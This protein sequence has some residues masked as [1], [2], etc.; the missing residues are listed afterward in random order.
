[1]TAKPENKP[2][3]I[4]EYYS[5]EGPFEDWINQFESIAEINRWGD[6]QKLRWLKVRL[7]GRA[8]K[9]YKKFPVT[10]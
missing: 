6:E 2:V 7:M 1:M 3:I 8:L 9:A 4:S 10:A 5:G